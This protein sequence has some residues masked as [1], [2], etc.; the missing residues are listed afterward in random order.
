MDERAI[1]KVL[2]LTGVYSSPS[3]RLRIIYMSEFLKKYGIEVK[4][5]RYPKK[6]YDLIK[7]LNSETYDLI[8]LQ[9]KMPDFFKYIIFKINKKP[10]V[11]DFDDNLI[12]RMKPKDGS[13]RSRTREIKFNLIKKISS[14]F[15]CG[16]KFLS[17][18]IKDEKKL[19][20]IYPTPVPVN[21]PKKDFNS[22]NS[23]IKIGWIGLSGGFMYLDKIFPDLLKL[24]NEVKFKLLIISDK[25]YKKDVD[26]IEN[27]RWKLETQENEISNF[28]LGI[29]P[30]N[31]ESPYDKGKCGY[32]ILQYMASGVIP[33][34]EAY[35]T[36]IEIIQDGING[37][38]VY[39]NRWYDKLKEIIVKIND[40]RFDYQKI[41]LNA[42]YA[43]KKH[44]SFEALAPKL[45]D[46][47]RK[48]NERK[49]IQVN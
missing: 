25:D 28:D 49:N 1:I 32:K 42:I 4:T 2:A 45:A 43:A 21:V 16:N 7:I 37:F 46:F 27:I 29:M 14:G 9:K 13:Y 3:T 44:Y 20:F 22:L 40:R 38:L 17:G 48:I 33:V 8:W 39:E 26:F 23:H 11:F 5:L 34:A 35:G 36:N 10:I 19:Y 12:V 30:L 18:L 15:T 24:Y 47:L 6:F 31:T 41:S